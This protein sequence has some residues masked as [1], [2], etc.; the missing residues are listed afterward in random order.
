MAIVECVVPPAQQRSSLVN[1]WD[2]EAEVPGQGHLIREER[3]TT[4]PCVVTPGREESS[5]KMGPFVT[6]DL[7]N[8]G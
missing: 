3:P 6:E 2:D 7:A 8:V 1:V 4:L 5:K